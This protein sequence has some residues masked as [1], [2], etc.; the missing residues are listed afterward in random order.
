MELADLARLQRNFDERRSTTFDWSG[1]ITKDNPR[2]LLHN[3]LSLSG[4]AGEV[5]NL[6]KKYDRGDFSFERLM[7]DLPEE[8]ADVAIYLIKI[9]YQSDIDLEQAILSKMAINEE[10]FPRSNVPLFGDQALTPYQ[11]ELLAN[12]AEAADRLSPGESGRV[13]L[14]Y[15]EVGVEPPADFAAA[16]TGGLLAI[17][18]ARAAVYEGSPV[19][20]D[21]IWN[22]LEPVARFVGM[23]KAEV[24]ALTQRDLQ[25]Q[26]II[27]QSKDRNV[28]LD[29]S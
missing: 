4:E 6:V 12:G 29:G 16:V 9:A 28:G 17:E 7:D 1:S 18:Y 3:V 8:L 2:P 24:S 23:T 13:L 10:R 5:A 22:S 27:D 19:E 15:R 21:R 14:M 20:K 26:A 11:Q 25:I